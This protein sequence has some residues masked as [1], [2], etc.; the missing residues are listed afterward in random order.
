MKNVFSFRKRKDPK[1]ELKGNEMYEYVR[2]I[3]IKYTYSRASGKVYELYRNKMF[4]VKDT[5][6]IDDLEK[7]QIY[8]SPGFIR[9]V[10]FDDLIPGNKAYLAKL[11]YSLYYLDRVD[12]D[13]IYIKDIIR[14]RDL[15]KEI[16]CEGK[17]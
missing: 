4:E 16:D 14:M 17:K 15:R 9:I 6:K 1:L 10:D 5:S 13:N 8:K 12:G 2:G 7:V 3:G 11:I